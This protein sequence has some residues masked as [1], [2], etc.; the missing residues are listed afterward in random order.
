[1]LLCGLVRSLRLACLGLAC[2]GLPQAVAGCGDDPRPPPFSGM[3]SGASGGMPDGTGGGLPTD[4]CQRPPEP[5]DTSLCGNEVVPVLLQRPN[6]YFVLDV[7]ASMSL[8]MDSGA[9]TRLEVAKTSVANLLQD[10][11]HRINYGVAVFPGGGPDPSGEGAC[12]RG[13]ELFETQEGDPV[14]CV[15]LR[16]PGPVLSSLLRVMNPIVPAGGTPLAATL[17]SLIAGVTALEGTSAV[18]LIT[19]GAPNC[20]LTPCAAD[21]CMLSVEGYSY[22]G[23]QCDADLNCCD[24]DVVEAP[25]AALNCVDRGAS[26]S[27]VTELAEAGVKT[28]VVGIPG[29]EFYV[30]LLDQLAEAGG[31]AQDGPRKY[32]AI[33]DGRA[34]QDALKAIGNDVA[35]TCD[36]ALQS[37]DFSPQLTNVYFD[38]QLVPSSD[39]DGWTYADQTIH[40]HGSYCDDLLGGQVVNVQVVS[41]CPTIVR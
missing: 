5:D 6:I 30:D 22:M 10:I 14:Q 34:L 2:L 18:V 20:G 25:L 3:P 7:S 28:Y 23:Q 32:F 41:G 24:P 12:G 16:R 33:S 35:V 15:N 39:T 31:T 29:T 1:M 17:D 40:L 37:D 36:I 26:L 27:A 4:D 38:S 13:E 9:T 8:P 11:G 21:E 19:D